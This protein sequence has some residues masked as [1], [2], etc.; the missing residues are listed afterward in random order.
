MLASWL[1]CQ[2]RDLHPTM[3]CGG[4]SP[5]SSPSPS[6]WLVLTLGAAGDGGPATCVGNLESHGLA[7][8]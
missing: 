8:A 2:L 6:L 7:L 4:L 5:G 3:E 1:Q